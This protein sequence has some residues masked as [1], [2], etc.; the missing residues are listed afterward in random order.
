MP[1][2]Q[3]EKEKYA[4]AVQALVTQVALAIMNGQDTTRVFFDRGFNGTG[5]DPITDADL[6]N[7]GITAVNLA[8]GVNMLQQLV[9]FRDNFAVLQSTWGVIMN[10]LRTD[11]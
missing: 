3:T 10:K 11:L 6:V 2:S 5:A 1:A 8:D 9:A 7:L 4:A